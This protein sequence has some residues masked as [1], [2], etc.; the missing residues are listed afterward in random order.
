MALTVASCCL[1]H[2]WDYIM[3][4]PLVQVG[5][6]ERWQQRWWQGGFIDWIAILPGH[7]LFLVWGMLT[8]SKV[9][10]ISYLPLAPTSLL[11]WLYHYCSSYAHTQPQAASGL[12]SLV[13]VLL[14]QQYLKFQSSSYLYFKENTTQESSYS[15]KSSVIRELLGS[16]GSICSYYV[17]FI[18]GYRKR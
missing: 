6:Q 15:S 3:L 4:P 2:L 18:M 5:N 11:I 17:L 10:D 8:A 13:A 9:K 7:L 16:H 12:R 14:P 1:E